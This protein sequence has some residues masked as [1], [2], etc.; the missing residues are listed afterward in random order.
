M[1]QLSDKQRRILEYISESTARR[2]YPPSVREI[3]EAVGLRSPSTVHA[4]I[5]ALKEAG[6]LNKDEHKTR[7]LSIPGD[8]FLRVPVLGRVTA[9]M[10]ILA[11]EEVEGYIPFDPGR[12]VGE[13][14]A[15]NV[16]GDSMI[17][18]GILDG[19]VVIVRRQ[20]TADSGAIVVAMI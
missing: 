17:N 10:P 19:D 11:V 13:H 8:S 16:R 5:K 6:Y 18:A 20:E 9:G 7:A 1:K 2:S 14:F 15:L 12:S 3:G 4:H